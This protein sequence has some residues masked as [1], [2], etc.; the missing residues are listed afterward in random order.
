MRISEVTIHDIKNYLR[1]DD[2]YDDNLIEII[3]DSAKH[4]I[5]SHT[6]LTE[7]ELEK[8]EDLTIALMVICHELYDNRRYMAETTTMNRANLVI[9]NILNKHC[10]NL[11]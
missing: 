7:V 4:H 5:I 6:G 8:R 3:L 1:I 10:T 11:L 9:E 2:S